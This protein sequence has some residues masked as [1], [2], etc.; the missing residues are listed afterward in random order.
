MRKVFTWIIVGFCILSIL[1]LLIFDK[2]TKDYISM[3]TI[4]QTYARLITEDEKLSFTV[5]VS[6]ADSFITDST[7]ITNCILKSDTNEISLNLNQIRKSTY[8]ETLDDMT[9]T[10]YIFDFDFNHL[11]L[12]DVVLDFKDA[13]LQLDYQNS[14]TIQLEV[15]DVFLHFTE[16][17][18]L[19]H[20]DVF[21]MYGV[22]Q[23]TD[24]PYLNGI[25][26][27]LRN[28]TLQSLDM[29][30]FDLLVEGVTLDIASAKILNQAPS[31]MSDVSTIMGYDYAQVGT[32]EGVGRISVGDDTLV[33]IPLKYASDTIQINRFPIQINYQYNQ[34]MYDY[35]MDD[36]QFNSSQLGLEVNRGI[37]REFVYYY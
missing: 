32:C 2:N 20:L 21:R 14:E 11:T 10:A 6:Q 25:V 24:E 30:S 3:I 8:T 12:D 27:G 31:Y 4:K 35:T 28:R 26:I 13:F 7:L 22:Y 37:L 1:A 17:N 18:N 33:Y 19:T 16:I 29:I 9:Y 23:K 15:G 34:E 5:Y 36:F